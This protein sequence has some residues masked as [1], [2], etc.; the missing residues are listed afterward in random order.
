MLQLEDDSSSNLEGCECNSHLADH[1]M[2]YFGNS[3]VMCCPRHKDTKEIFNGHY[4]K[5]STLGAKLGLVSCLDPFDH[6]R[7]GMILQQ[8]E[9]IEYE[10][11]R[12]SISLSKCCEGWMTFHLMERKA[13]KRAVTD[14]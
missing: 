7:H 11:C 14:C 8:L 9:K 1:F 5:W 3:D 12:I 13:D 10:L 6:G 2:N 4:N